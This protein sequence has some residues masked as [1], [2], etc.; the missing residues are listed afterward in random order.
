MDIFALPM[1]DEDL[2]LTHPFVELKQIPGDTCAHVCFFAV[3]A[4]E[5]TTV[6]GA[7]EGVSQV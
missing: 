4:L 6:I 2:V 5:E 3:R 7:L 1:G